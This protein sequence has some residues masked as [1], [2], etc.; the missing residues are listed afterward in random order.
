MMK[1]KKTS[2]ETYTCY[3]FEKLSLINGNTHSTKT[4]ACII[5]SLQDVKTSARAGNYAEHEDLFTY[6]KTLNDTG[7]STKDPHRKLFNRSNSTGQI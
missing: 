6:L 2:N 7:G 1:R 4:V 3:Y 5:H